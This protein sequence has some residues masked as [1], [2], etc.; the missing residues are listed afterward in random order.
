MKKSQNGLVLVI[1]IVIIG[2]LL[3]IAGGFYF[4]SSSNIE[5]TKQQN[6]PSSVSEPFVPVGWKQYSDKKIGFS[7]AYP[8]TWTVKID[9]L[10]AITIS[11]PNQDIDGQYGNMIVSSSWQMR[12]GNKESSQIIESLVKS[13]EQ[14][15][16]SNISGLKAIKSVK[17]DS[18]NVYQTT[19]YFIA[20]SR[21]NL[22]T[23]LWSV[24]GVT[25]NIKAGMK[26]EAKDT[27]SQITSSLVFTQ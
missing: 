19:T 17:I 24:G 5:Q 22:V 26:S 23:E 1:I 11:A 3:V 6:T 20:D 10:S 9:S 21:Y 8:P 18:A 14:G 16:N 12:L 7:V 25:D 27:L 4:M 15:S 2:V 13:I